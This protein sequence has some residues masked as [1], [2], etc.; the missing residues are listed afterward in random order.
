ML[1]THKVKMDTAQAPANALRTSGRGPLSREKIPPRTANPT[2]KAA[3]RMSF[4]CNGTVSPP[5]GNFGYSR[6]V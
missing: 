2:T 6:G 4:V 3:V 1:A 5:L